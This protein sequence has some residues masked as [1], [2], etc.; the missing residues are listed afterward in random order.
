MRA[1]ISYACIHVQVKGTLTTGEKHGIGE[2][3]CRLCI[4][5]KRE[6]KNEGRKEGGKERKE[7]RKN[8]GEKLRCETKRKLFYPLEYKYN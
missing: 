7:I 2:D 6:K 4:V 3:V 5:R 8:K 1:L